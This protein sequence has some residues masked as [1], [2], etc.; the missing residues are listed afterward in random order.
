MIGAAVRLDSKTAISPQ[1][2]LGTETMRCLDDRDQQG[3]PDWT[4]R[5]NLAEQLER[6]VL[7]ALG[8]Q[9]APHLLAQ[10]PQRIELL[11]VELRP[12][13]HSRL[14][15]LAEPLGTIARR[16]DLLTGA[17]NGPTA[18]HRLEARHHASQIAAD[19]HITA[20]QFLQS[21]YAMLSVIDRLELV[22]VQQFG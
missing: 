10:R 19:R 17:G 22:Q 8:Q 18:V 9:F 11:V 12:A 16:I 5:G 21:S 6:L 4:D 7:P 20:R 1:L 15:D 13:P 14:S 3:R 2:P